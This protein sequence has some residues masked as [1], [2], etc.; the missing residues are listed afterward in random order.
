[1]GSNIHSITWHYREKSLR[2]RLRVSFIYWT[3]SSVY[4]FDLKFGTKETKI[5]V[6]VK[7]SSP[8]ICLIP[9]S[10]MV[11]RISQLERWKFKS[12]HWTVNFRLWPFLTKS[13]KSYDQSINRETTMRQWRFG[14]P[15]R[16]PEGTT[17]SCK[18]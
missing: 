11:Y 5:I 9:M 18:P 7:L 15:D 16:N 12:R 3:G 8:Y 4:G 14:V 17:Y 10:W 1:M 13:G 2:L 6:R